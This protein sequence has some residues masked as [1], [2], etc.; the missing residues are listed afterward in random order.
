M[1]GLRFFIRK[2]LYGEILENSKKIQLI[3]EGLQIVNIKVLFVI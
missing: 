3:K 2:Y 1:S